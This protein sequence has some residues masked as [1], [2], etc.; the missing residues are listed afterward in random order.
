M[1]PV[2]FDDYRERMLRVLVFIQQNLD[3]ELSLEE[4]AGL[5]HLS[6]Y[7]FHR[8]F[9]G[10][11]GESLKAHIRR[12]RLE[13]AALRLRSTRDAV[14]RIALDAG[15]ESHQAFTRAFRAMTG[16]SP[17]AFR[18][19]H[20]QPRFSTAPSGVR[21]APSDAGG[22]F[23]PLEPGGATMQVSIQHLGP[24]RVAFTRHIG[25]Y[26]Q[27]APVWD[28]FLTRMGAAGLLGAGTKFI[29]MCHDDP[30]ITPTARTRYDCC[31]T[32]DESFEPAGPIGVQTIPEGDYAVTTHHGP[33]DRLGE[34]YGKLCGEWIPRS[35]RA[36]R[37]APCLEA[38]LNSP[39][40]TEPAE[41]LTDI[42]MPLEST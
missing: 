5:A 10:M 7:H 31:V 36:L 11:V 4:L 22:A 25:P 39:E 32:V 20:R 1:K 16:S 24:W 33:Y 6:P 14:T 18:A 40:S 30:D 8:I 15:Y 17:S 13:R 21:Y 34:T 38:Y 9:R 3:R 41:L 29:G 12:I 19:R 37:S 35:G 23:T 28:D 42:Y 27:C 26:D 2:T